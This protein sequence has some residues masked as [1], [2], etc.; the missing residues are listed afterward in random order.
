MSNHSVL[1]HRLSQGS[2]PSGKCRDDQFWCMCSCFLLH[3]IASYP[4]AE[5]C[6]EEKYITLKNVKFGCSKRHRNT[7]KQMDSCTIVWL[8]FSLLVCQL[9][10]LCQLYC[11]V[12]VGCYLLYFLFLPVDQAGTSS[13]VILL[14][15]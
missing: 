1:E 3:K 7:P 4:I 12:L 10:F 6:V 9:I 14:C 13:N 5:E 8:C 11:A 2:G 15:G